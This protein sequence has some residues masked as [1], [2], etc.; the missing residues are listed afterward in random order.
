MKTQTQKGISREADRCLRLVVAFHGRYKN[1]VFRLS[2][3]FVK[4][5]PKFADAAHYLEEDGDFE[6]RASLEAGLLLRAY[7]ETLS[8]EEGKALFNRFK[9]ERVARKP[10]RGIFGI[11][12]AYAK[13]NGVILFPEDK[14]YLKNTDEAPFPK[15]QDLK[16]FRDYLK[17]ARESLTIV[18]AMQ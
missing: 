2:E 18:R 3:E 14:G 15:R 11:V 13:R 9:A 10:Y 4:D 7:I 1:E 8:L 6:T 5:F 17:T 12:D 16:S